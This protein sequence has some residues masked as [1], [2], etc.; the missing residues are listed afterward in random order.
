MPD[1]LNRLISAL[2]AWLRSASTTTI[3]TL[4]TSVVAA[5][6]R[7]VNWTMGA[8]KMT[9]KIRGSCLSSRTSFHIMKKIRRI[10]LRPHAHCFFS[11][12]EAMVSMK[13]AYRARATSSVQNTFSPAPFRTI[14]RS[15]TMKYRA[16]T[17]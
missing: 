17:M 13:A 14:A 8:M 9:E 11:R 3:G 1:A 7:T 4:C 6:P 10:G 12:V 15:A 2:L 16:G 5:Y